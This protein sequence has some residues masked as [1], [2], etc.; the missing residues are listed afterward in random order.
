METGM[1]VPNLQKEPSSMVNDSSSDAEQMIPERFKTNRPPGRR[2]GFP[3]HHGEDIVGEG[4]EPPPSGIGKESFGRHH[5]SCQVIFED[6]VNLFHRPTAFSLPL[7]QSLSIPTPHVGDDGKIVI[8]VAVRKEFSLKGL[9]TNYELRSSQDWVLSHTKG[10]CR[11][12]KTL[13]PFNFLDGTAL[14]CSKG[15]YRE[16]FLEI[17]R[18]YL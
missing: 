5:A 6:I 10:F 11:K 4:I 17:T 15:Y 16:K 7:Q 1:L 18:L 3:L 14:F 8:G 12:S 2:Q 13:P 9:D